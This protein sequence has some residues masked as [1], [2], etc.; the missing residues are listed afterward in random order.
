MLCKLRHIGGP[1]SPAI[2]IRGFTLYP[3][4][5]SPDVELNKELP[6]YDLIMSW[7]E[8][9]HL[10][11]ILPPTS[12]K[13]KTGKGNKLLHKLQHRLSKRD[14]RSRRAPPYVPGR[15]TSLSPGAAR[16]VPGHP[17]GMRSTPKSRILTDEDVSKGR[18]EPIPPGPPPEGPSH[19]RTKRG[20]LTEDQVGPSRPETHE[21][22]E[23]EGTSEESKKIAF[24]AAD[25][26]GK[27]KR[28]EVDD[29]PK[30]RGS[31][32]P[33]EEKSTEITLEEVVENFSDFRKKDLEAAAKEFDIDYD[34][35]L[36][37]APLIDFLA[38]YFLD[39]DEGFQE[40]FVEKLMEENEK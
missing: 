2:S 22:F 25:K 35:D 36:N 38:E 9:E 23:P 32:T 33:E 11:Q 20:M 10:L 8:E 15:R 21:E 18:P 13:I 19:V 29:V 12:D 34:T 5:V 37:K 30:R 27:A 31:A 4:S 3:G 26:A 24:E 6:E 14:V 16:H 39:Q 40:A 1:G 17:F 28:M 7:V